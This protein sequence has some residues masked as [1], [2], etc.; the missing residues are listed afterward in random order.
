MANICLLCLVTVIVFA[1]IGMQL[2]SGFLNHRCVL[3]NTIV[4]PPNFK[5]EVWLQQDQQY[6]D[7]DFF[8]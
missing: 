8:C 4:D 5:T 1:A 2:F 3:E 6:H 7:M